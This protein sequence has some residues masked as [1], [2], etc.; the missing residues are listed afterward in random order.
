MSYKIHYPSLKKLSQL[1]Y[2][3]PRVNMDGKKIHIEKEGV[4]QKNENTIHGHYVVYEDSGFPGSYIGVHIGSELSEDGGDA[5]INVVAI[6]PSRSAVINRVSYRMRQSRV[7]EN[8]GGEGIH[9]EFQFAKRMGMINESVRP[10]RFREL[11]VGD[12][13]RFTDDNETLLKVSATHYKHS[14]IK[15]KQKDNSELVVKI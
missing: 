5:P 4:F 7:T 12:K 2:T 3:D 10:V 9:E 1:E 8:S 14:G 11:A 15:Y 6:D 13:F